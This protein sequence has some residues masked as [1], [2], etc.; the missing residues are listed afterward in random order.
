MPFYQLDTHSHGGFTTVAFSQQTVSATHFRV[1]SSCNGT[2]MTVPRL[3]AGSSF[4]RSYLCTCA[5]SCDPSRRC[6]R[7]VLAQHISPVPAVRQAP[8]APVQ[9]AALVTVT[10]G[11]IPNAHQQPQLKYGAPVQLGEPVSHGAATETVSSVNLN[12]DD[13]LDVLQQPQTG[14]AAPVQYSEPAVS[15]AAPAPVV[16]YISPAPTGSCVASA[17][18]VCAVLAPVAEHN[19]PAH[20]VIAAPARV[21]D[22]TTRAPAVSAAPASSVSC[23]IPRLAVNAAS[24]PV[25][26]F[27]AQLLRELQHLHRQ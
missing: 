12:K 15:F 19:A 13:S 9:H 21:V 14:C 27:T 20:A 2:G 4:A 6:P 18:A 16:E 22:S 24:A 25:V 5:W 10:G 11:G 3:L 17:P 1:S 8:P 23:I 7:Q 26:K